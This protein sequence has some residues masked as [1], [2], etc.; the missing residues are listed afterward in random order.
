MEFVGI[1]GFKGNCVTYFIKQVDVAS[2]FHSS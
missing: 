2:V 1:V